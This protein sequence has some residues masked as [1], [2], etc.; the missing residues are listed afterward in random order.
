MKSKLFIA[1]IF[2]A[3]TSYSQLYF[4]V[5]NVLGNFTGISSYYASDSYSLLNYPT[6]KADVWGQDYELH[7]IDMSGLFYWLMST[8][9]KDGKQATNVHTYSNK[10][11]YQVQDRVSLEYIKT[12]FQE[13]EKSDF[14]L[15]GKGWQV[16]VRKFGVDNGLMKMDI[17]DSV[18]FGP[19][20]GPYY[21]GGML[22]GGFNFQRKRQLNNFLTI[23]S[24][25]Y[26]NGLVGVMKFG[27]MI[28]PEITVE[29]K[30][31]FLSLK[32]EAQYEVAG[33]YGITQNAYKNFERAK[34]TGFVYGA[35][36]D[37]SV[38]IDLRK[39]N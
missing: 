14:I 15:N 29:A 5:Q 18:Y 6:V 8:R 38:G 16:G 39:D 31:K 33:M 19:D 34:N 37:L 36:F 24:G 32:F 26:A 11:L 21:R 17:I 2:I 28:Y 25:L 35:R 27:A 12:K 4:G 3:S 22:S 20:N 7:H 1:F 9:E 10:Y 23:R 13:S 30:Y